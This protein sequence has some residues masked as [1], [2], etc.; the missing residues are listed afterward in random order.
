[1]NR[2]E[3]QNREIFE[4]R[5]RENNL[6]LTPQRYAIYKELLASKDHPNA[7][8]VYRRL[9]GSFPNI[10]FDTVNRT[11]LTLCDIGIAS[12]VEFPGG[13]KRFDADISK[14]HHFRCIK[15]NGLVDFVSESY[16]N[17]EVP[18]EIQLQYTILKKKVHLEGICDR[19]SKE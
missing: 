4:K 14:H 1:M 9:R 18:Q 13:P 16:D 3:E 7:E 5:C 12:V 6:K 17:I 10:S 11:L 2:N 19:C 8:V 15:C